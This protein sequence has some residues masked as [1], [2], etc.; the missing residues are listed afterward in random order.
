MI[1]KFHTACNTL[2]ININDNITLDLIKKKYRI[3]AL[4]Y[5]PDKNKSKNSNEQFIKIQENYEY[6]LNH[7]NYPDKIDNTSHNYTNILSTFIK[8]LFPNNTQNEVISNII[9]K[10]ICN[11]E[12][13]TLTYLHQLDLLTLKQIY[14]IIKL[15]KN[16]FHIEDIVIEK[17]Y[18]IIIQKEKGQETIILNPSIDD[19]FNNN[20]YKLNKNNI[21]HVIPLWHHDLMYD[22]SGNEINIKCIPSL[23]N[24]ITIDENNN[25]YTSLNL[26]IEN[27]WNSDTIKF[28]LGD[29]TI[30]FNKSMLYLKKKQT[31]VLDKQGISTINT[32]NVFDISKKSNIIINITL[33]L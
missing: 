24:N 19:L 20:I 26:N 8:T 29:Q 6:L 7:Y 16:P 15:Y 5:H 32:S 22:S 31:I 4:L 28:Q 1:T 14:N 30:T 12:T 17:I 27:I 3:K 21:T 23:P 10:I 25:I 9:K 18:N 11:C 13:H 33:K 2:D